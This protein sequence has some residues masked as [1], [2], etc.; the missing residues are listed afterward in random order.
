MEWRNNFD[1]ILIT[2]S[3]HWFLT[4]ERGLLVFTL[5]L[6]ST[7]YLLDFIGQV[8]LRFDIWAISR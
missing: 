5:S 6:Q 8:T 1:L 2:E 3:R 7:S 4:Y